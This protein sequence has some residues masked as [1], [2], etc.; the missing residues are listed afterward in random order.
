MQ[1]IDRDIRNIAKKLRDTIDEIDS[2]GN[3]LD[4]GKVSEARAVCDEVEDELARVSWSKG[5]PA[6]V[7]ADGNVVPLDTK[8]A[9][10]G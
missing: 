9:D 10:R 7:D 6:P 3:C 8:E 2:Q 1:N 5:V 4:P